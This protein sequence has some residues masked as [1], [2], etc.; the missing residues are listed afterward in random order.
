MF[1][2][3]QYNNEN[4]SWGFFVEEEDIIYSYEN[5]DLLVKHNYQKNK[6]R[7]IGTLSNEH[8][9]DSSFNYSFNK[10]PKNSYDDIR[11]KNLN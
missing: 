6:K 11:K 4:H 10:S 8:F 2:Q 5:N 9:D 1:Q 7:T 3:N